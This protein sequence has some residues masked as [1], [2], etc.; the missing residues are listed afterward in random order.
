MY[1]V[2]NY[3]LNITRNHSAFKK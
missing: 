3:T 1:T 2:T